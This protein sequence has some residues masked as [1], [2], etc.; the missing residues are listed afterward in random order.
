MVKMKTV[1]NQHK[2]MAMATATA[3]A[4]LSWLFLLLLATLAFP[5][6]AKIQALR[7][8]PAAFS[9]FRLKI[10]FGYQNIFFRG[11]SDDQS[12]QAV[13]LGEDEDESA[14]SDNEKESLADEHSVNA[15]IGTESR[16]K[17]Q[18]KHRKRSRIRHTSDMLYDL[19]ERSAITIPESLKLRQLITQ[20]SKEYTEDIFVRRKED[21]MKKLTHPKKLLHF[22][23]PK[24]PAIKHS[25]DV[26]LR[27]QTTRTDMD[28]GV[29]A[30]LIGT[31]AHICEIYDNELLLQTREKEEA[32]PS[33]RV[34]EVARPA[35]SSVDLIKDRRFEQ[36]VEC[37]LCGV[38]VEKRMREHMTNYLDA[39]KSDDET[40]GNS[41]DVDNILE[42]E[43]VQ[44]R[45]GLYIRDACR[46]AWGLAIL[47]ANHCGTLGGTKV[48]D[49]HR[50]L[51]LRIRESLLSRLQ[52]LRQGDL[53]EDIRVL[54]EN[55]AK[56]SPE[57]RLY[58]L[59]EE[60]AEDAATAMWTFAC[61]RACTGMRSA[62]LFETCCSILCQD[63]FEIR[64]QAQ[65][66]Q[67]STEQSTIGVNDVVDRLAR[68]EIEDKGEEGEKVSENT[69]AAENIESHPAE[70]KATTNLDSKETLIDWLS[71]NELTDVLWALALHGHSDSNVREEII[72]SENAAVLKEIAF[73]R[74]MFLLRE[75][76]TFLQKSQEEQNK[77]AAA[78]DELINSSK[79]EYVTKEGE[80]MTVEVVDA[81]ALL[82]SENAAKTAV[83]SS[84]ENMTKQNPSGGLVGTSEQVEVVDAAAILQTSGDHVDHELLTAEREVLV[85][86]EDEQTT[87]I[88]EAF[89]GENDTAE[90]NTVFEEAIPVEDLN[91]TADSSN[92]IVPTPA[93]S[94]QM[95]FSAHDLCALAWAVTELRDSLRFQ[96]VDLVI[97]IFAN[98]G[99]DSVENMTGSDLANLAWAISR[100]ILDA[101]PWSS[102]TV[103]RNSLSLTIWM[104]KRALITS[105]GHLGGRSPPNVIHMLDSFQPPELSRMMWAVASTVRAFT[106][107][108]DDY[109]PAVDQLAINALLT[110]ASNLSLFSAEDMVSSE[111]RVPYKYHR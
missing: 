89:T 10:N 27:I 95:Y 79:E 80:T 63:P 38:D 49:L 72:L 42:G 30:C 47:G 67:L 25:P 110:T 57:E 111:S 84:V 82:A 54:D 3:N 39:K 26:T 66:A 12:E 52:L 7:L 5:S 51:S 61:V 105:G 101:R 28:A 31:L 91:S 75:D 14:P 88:E 107:K 81:A 18:T 78:K 15:T 13:G 73:D 32:S 68:S 9:A 23:A 83:V 76:Y 62:P 60:L 37:L 19:I 43:Q 41:N 98:L 50:A 65:E 40:G 21:P 90:S 33:D 44:V 71:P 22:I 96:I 1:R 108:D 87:L 106:D 85:D 8:L 35:S 53:M 36:V 69:T 93:L 29:A 104:V 59:S 11:G 100:H 92:E 16:K 102:K 70:P 99:E 55:F 56:L 6:S 45:E 64:K 2:R 86:E 34:K 109:Y 24:I 4:N 46:A 58:E 103:N 77:T 94:D 17:Q 48:I 97:N 20:R 74:L